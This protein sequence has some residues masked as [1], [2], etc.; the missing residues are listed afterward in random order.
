MRIPIILL[1]TVIFAS[2]IGSCT[3]K[4]NQGSEGSAGELPIV[5]DKPWK[6]T[7]KFKLAAAL[8]YVYDPM[9]VKYKDFELED[10][11][12]KFVRLSDFQG[13][14]ILL[15]FW[16][17]TATIAENELPELDKLYQTMKDEGMVI[18][19]VNLQESKETVKDFVKKKGLHFPVLLDQKG[20]L[21]KVYSRIRVP[22]AY[23]IDPEGYLA[24]ATAGQTK[25][26]TPQ[27][28]EIFRI[29][30]KKLDWKK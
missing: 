19:S 25:W 27:M 24:A 22:T 4:S 20:D 8:F 18:V 30:I 1:C 28:R 23:I 6:Q 16:A 12:G 9:D 14:A 7:I 11:D 21:E 26:N 2:T 13:K 29:L 5:M 10:L 15:Y 17:T 3:Q